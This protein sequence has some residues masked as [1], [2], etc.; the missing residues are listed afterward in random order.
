[1]L[2]GYLSAPVTIRPAGAVPGRGGQMPDFR[3][4]PAEVTAIAGFL[5]DQRGA[6]VPAW[7]PLALSPFASAK[8][9]TLLRDRWSCL[10][11]HQLGDDGGRIGPRLDGIGDRLQPGYVRALVQTPSTRPEPSCRTA[12]AAAGGLDRVVPGGA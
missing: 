4:D 9:A 3:L 1:M 6:E 10:G 11:C 12:R 5:M 2:A 7:E 8:T